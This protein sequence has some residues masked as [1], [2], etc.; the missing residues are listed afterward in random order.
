MTTLLDTL[1]KAGL[2]PSAAQIYLSL[3]ENGEMSVP[4]ILKKTSLSRAMVY[5][6]LPTLLFKGYVEYRK[7]GRNVF[8]KPVHPGKLHDLIEQKKRD[9]MLLENELGNT[10]KTLGGLYNL[11]NNKPGVRFFE[12]LDGIKEMLNNTF[13]NNTQKELRTFTDLAGYSD[14][15]GEWNA[16]YYAPKRKELGI[17]LQ[18]IVT[19]HPKALEFLKNYEATDITEVLFIDNTVFPLASEINI[20]EDQVSII[21]FSKVTP[22]GIL[23]NNKD[24][25]TTM[26]SIFQFAWIMGKK[27]NSLPQPEWKKA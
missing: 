12:G 10:I 1:T 7:E 25:A 3:A 21:T 4:E 11:A 18:G 17:R 9:T 6:I 8:Y 2:E 16:S 13:I 5:Q 27:N 20:Y 22:V 15:L 23:I 19:N 24:I 26:K 14:A